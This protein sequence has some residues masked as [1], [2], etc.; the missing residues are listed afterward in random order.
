M[1]VIFFNHAWFLASVLRPQKQD[2]WPRLIASL[3]SLGRIFHVS[4]TTIDTFY[5]LI[6][7]KCYQR[8]TLRKHNSFQSASC[9][10]DSAN[11]EEKIHSQR[12]DKTEKQLEAEQK[13][14]QASR[15]WGT[16][17]GSWKGR[18]AEQKL[19]SLEEDDQNIQCQ[20]KN[21]S[22]KESSYANWTFNEL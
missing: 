5:N 21:T 15:M 17:A 2:V 8:L 1:I 18:K 7:L 20:G 11:A 6:C 14:E 16:Q 22:R 3:W 10:L 9:A 19:V 4:F 12:K 13:V